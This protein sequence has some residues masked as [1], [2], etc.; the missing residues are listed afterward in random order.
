MYQ[1]ESSPFDDVSEHTMEGDQ[2]MSM[3]GETIPTM[4]ETL[5]ILTSIATGILSALMGL[6][7]A[8]LGVAIAVGMRCESAVFYGLLLMGTVLV[9]GFTAFYL[10]RFAHWP[11]SSTAGVV[12]ALVA[13]FFCWSCGEIYGLGSLEWAIFGGLYGAMW[14][15]PVGAILG[16][17]GLKKELPKAN[18][19]AS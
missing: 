3:Y 12:G 10:P 9:A 7:F 18:E 13:T 11:S 8:I 6:L 14:G 15:L 4:K 17:L 16:P 5:R 2:A 19:K 1:S